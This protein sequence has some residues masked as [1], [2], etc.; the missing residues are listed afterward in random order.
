V[1]HTNEPSVFPVVAVLVSVLVPDEVA[2][3]ELVLVTLDVILLEP[4]VVLLTLAEVVP[5]DDAVID[6]VDETEVV[7]D[8]LAV[9][10]TE[11]VPERETEL[12]AVEDRVL[13]ADELAVDVCVDNS[14]VRNRP[15]SIAASA[16]FKYDT[17]VVH[18]SSLAKAL[19]S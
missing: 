14:H 5:D 15:D 16:S 18:S 12:V 7:S 1:K 10:D 11:D 13:E 2:E 3:S 6:S 8:E 9:E 4:V 19:F 17:A